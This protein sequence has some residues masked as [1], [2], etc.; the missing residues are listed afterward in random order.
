MAEP[1]VP[2]ELEEDAQEPSIIVDNYDDGNGGA[3]ADTQEESDL[4][5]DVPLNPEEVVTIEEE[6]TPLAITMTGLVQHV[7]WFAGLAGVSAA[8]AGVTVFEIKRRA[9]A[10]IIDKLNQ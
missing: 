10:K 3:G 8:G 5:I 6:P 1:E 2:E 4:P 9:A 7:K